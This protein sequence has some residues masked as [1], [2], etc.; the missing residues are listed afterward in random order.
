MV[1]FFLYL[2]GI[3]VPSLR[4][5]YLPAFSKA[6]KTFKIWLRKIQLNQN[7]PAASNPASF[8]ASEHNPN[9]D[10][11][12][13]RTQIPRNWGTPSTWT[14]FS[15]HPLPAL[16]YSSTGK[17]NLKG[18]LPNRPSTFYGGGGFAPRH[19]GD[20]VHQG[21]GVAKIPGV[22]FIPEENSLTF[23]SENS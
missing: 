22:Q 17:N 5:K 4:S 8:N 2:C 23:V 20:M 19:S 21:G 9:K 1:F 6:L 14:S 12:R 13:K 10:L 18:R 16:P 3:F 11:P 15:P 7:L